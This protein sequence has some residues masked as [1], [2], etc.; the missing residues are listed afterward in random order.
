MP[1]STHVYQVA[2]CTAG[3][4]VEFKGVFELSVGK[5]KPMTYFEYN[6]GDS[7]LGSPVRFKVVKGGQM[8]G[9]HTIR[10][11]LLEID[12]QAVKAGLTMDSF[13]HPQ[14]R[15]QGL[16][17]RLVKA[18]SQAA[19]DRGWEV[20]LGFANRNSINIYKNRLGH[21]EPGRLQCHVLEAPLHVTQS[22]SFDI[23][24]K[25]LPDSAE[26]ILRQDKSREGFRVSVLKNL[27]YLEW[28]YMQSPESLYQVLS[29]GEAYFCILKDYGNEVQIVDFFYTD[30][31]YLPRLL[32]NCIEY[33][34]SNRKSLSFWLPGGHRLLGHCLTIKHHT[35]NAPQHLHLA[36]GRAMYSGALCELANWYYV[37][38]DSDVF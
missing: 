15:K 27:P 34:N 24:V 17:T 38:G 22:L 21:A 13:I 26:A 28:R 5:T 7:P 1:D 20:I 36:T 23:E 35:A 29:N 3:D 4:L 11:L 6:Q 33:A 16:F 25:R 32:A 2:E 10:P 18:T 8:V 14:H 31:V 9:S 12:G 37:M 30:K 19:R